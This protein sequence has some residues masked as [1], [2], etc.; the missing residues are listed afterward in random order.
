[1]SHPFNYPEF[2]DLFSIFITISIIETVWPS[3][4]Q[5]DYTDEYYPVSQIINGCCLTFNDTINIITSC[6]IICK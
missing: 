6:K 5:N 2:Y 4:A 1:M 3:K